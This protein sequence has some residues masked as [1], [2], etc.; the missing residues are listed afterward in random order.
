MSDSGISGL[1]S[2]R[3]EA[4][5]IASVVGVDVLKAT[6]LDA[7]LSKLKSTD[8]RYYRVLH[9]AT[10]G[11]IDTA[12]PEMS[13]LILSLV[14]ARGASQNGFLRLPDI[15]SL[16][17]HAELVVLSAC[18]TALGKEIRGEGLMSLNWAFMHAG[19]S[20][21]MSTLW[22]IDDSATAKL[23]AIFYRKL[24]REGMSPARS[25]REAQIEMLHHRQWRSAFFWASFVLQGGPD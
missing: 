25:L 18:E 24:F 2:S 5:A 21:V 1:P 14:N 10:H 3:E 22:K 8:L 17:L 12:R 13:S 11:L 15:C 16:N 4:D 7:S 20:R 23:M 6:G 9:F 19:A